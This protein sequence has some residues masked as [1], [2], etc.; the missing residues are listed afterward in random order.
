MRVHALPHSHCLVAGYSMIL[1][2]VFLI[3]GLALVPI[4]TN[5]EFFSFGVPVTIQADPTKVIVLKSKTKLVFAVL[6]L[7]VEQLIDT[8]L[9]EAVAWR[10]RKDLPILYEIV[11]IVANYLR[12]AT[13]VVFMRSQISF[14][15][16]IVLADLIA[17]L[18]CRHYS[19]LRRGGCK[20]AWAEIDVGIITAVRA[21][22]IGLFFGVYALA[23]MYSTPYFSVGPPLLVFEGSA[24]TSEAQYWLITVCVF[25]FAALTCAARNNIDHWMHAVVQ[26]TGVETTGFSAA[27]TRAVVLVRIVLYYL[28]IMFL[29]TFITTQFYF[30]AVYAIAD[31]V[32][33]LL[34]RLRHANVTA[35]E[36]WSMVVTLTVAQ[37]VFVLIVVIVISVSHWFD[38]EYFTW[39]KGVRVFGAAVDGGKAVSLLLSY[40]AFERVAVTFLSSIVQSDVSAWLFA[41]APNAELD[42][43]THGELLALVCVSR[44]A[45][46]F[47]FVLRIQFILTNYA[48][49]V[50]SAAVDLPLTIAV[51]E[52]HI[53][54]KENSRQN[55]RVLQEYKKREEAERKCRPNTESPIGPSEVTSASLPNSSLAPPNSLMIPPAFA[56][57][58]RK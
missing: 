53:I 16:F 20:S 9:A 44:V 6:L 5:N 45:E 29:Y 50:V 48:F 56:R 27:E 31:I 23:G 25:A 26:N 47:Y 14:V 46:W 43:Y 34:W 32:V 21:M 38:D 58:S 19:L 49:P 57:I 39:G 22:T 30:V 2:Y 52:L 13:H 3:Y 24:V 17:T 41:N 37:T 54:Y 51:N 15:L 28:S 40:V 1:I 36:D 55:T 42:E 12:Y 10:S 18:V 11:S 33:T 8:V 4:F 7:A 35:Q